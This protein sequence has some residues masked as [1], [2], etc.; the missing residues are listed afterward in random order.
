[1]F[2]WLISDFMETEMKSLKIFISLILSCLLVSACGPIHPTN[3]PLGMQDITPVYSSQPISLIESQKTKKVEVGIRLKTDLTEWNKQAINLI[4]QWLEKSH[5][6]V[7]DNA[8][9]HLKISISDVSLTRTNLG[10]TNLSLNVET[11]TGVQRS[12]PVRGCAGGY[13]RSAGYAINYAVVDLMRDGSIIKY[14][15]DEKIY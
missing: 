15:S 6:Q 4:K 7:V 12:Y 9:K 10:C 5:V 13:N 14:L 2:P 3:V 11:G 1:M 8:E